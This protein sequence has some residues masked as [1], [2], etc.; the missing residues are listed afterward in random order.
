MRATLKDN[1]LIVIPET[2]EE[3][4]AFGA[5]RTAHKGH[6]FRLTDGGT[7]GGALQG[8]GRQVDACREPI[9]IAFNVVEPRWRVISN[10]AASP[11]ELRGRCYESVEGFWQGLKFSGEAQRAEIAQMSGVEAVR[12]GS[13][14]DS[15]GEFVLDGRTHAFGGPGHHALMREACWAKFTQYP[16]AR[17]A[18]LATGERPL[19]HRVRR[20]SVTIP[21]AL[22][23]DIW[24]RIRV[25][26]RHKEDEQRDA[27]GCETICYF[28]RDR[29]LYGFMS[30]FEPSPIELDGECWP[31]VEHYYQFQKSFDPDYRAAIRA[32][33]APGTVKQLATTAKPD[34]ANAATS[35]F[36]RTGQAPRP[37]WAEVKLDI[38][39]R[40][41]WAKFSQNPHLAGRLLETGE[42][43][44]IEDSPYDAYWGT[45]PNGD[46]LNWAGRVL[47]E[48]RETL[49]KAPQGR[50]G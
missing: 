6:V 44:L 35:W 42:A 4:V 27:G 39:R 40:A 48:I 50:G 8:L 45:G 19:T 31:T 23:A 15:E 34:G 1:M 46:G 33:Q 24:M 20:D 37:D 7:K 41:D 38:M 14:G 28:A 2:D 30:H 36:A 13:E 26:L 5:W 9:N 47:M 11:F 18:L 17:R 29:D 49:R 21:G 25:R 22:M 3:R 43:E 10:L 12:A 16:E 32:A